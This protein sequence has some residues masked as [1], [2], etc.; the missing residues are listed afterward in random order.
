MRER[1]NELSKQ[2]APNQPA[3]SVLEPE[4]QI[5]ALRD[6]VRQLEARVQHLE[7]LQIRQPP[8]LVSR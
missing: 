5:A 2:S 6:Y 4:L 3:E 1:S 8:R 7:K